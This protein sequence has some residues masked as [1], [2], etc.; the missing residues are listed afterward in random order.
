MA[1]NLISWPSG[2]SRHWPP[3]LHQTIALMATCRA[4]R[5]IH[6]RLD[7]SPPHANAGAL[8]HEA[9]TRG[10]VPSTAPASI[11]GAW[12]DQSAAAAHV[13]NRAAASATA[14]IATYRPG[15]ALDLR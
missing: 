15:S 13:T 1:R 11:D 6:V 5:K 10:P 3:R 2:R 9:V 4:G 8:H 14:P 12:Q 7:G